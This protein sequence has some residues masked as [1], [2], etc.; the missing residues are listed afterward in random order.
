MGAAPTRARSLYR[1]FLRELPS[2]SP[3]ILANPSPI[4]KQ[5]RSDF[6]SSEQ[7]ESKTEQQRLDEAEQHVLYLKSQRMYITLL[8]R[9]NPGANMNEEERVR[10]TARRVGLDLPVEM[11]HGGSSDG[12]GGNESG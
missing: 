4:Q 8:E 1:R 9:Y 7:H 5:I 12:D 6:S 10:L 11:Q 2:R 3:S